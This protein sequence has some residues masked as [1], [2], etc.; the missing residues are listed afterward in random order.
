M[1]GFNAIVNEV[2]VMGLEQAEQQFAALAY[3]EVVSYYARGAILDHAGRVWFPAK[4]DYQDWVLKRIRIPLELATRFRRVYLGINRAG[5]TEGDFRGIPISSVLVMLPLLTSGKAEVKKRIPEVLEFARG[6]SVEAVRD[7][8]YQIR[9]VQRPGRIE[10]SKSI[11]A[12]VA[13]KDWGRVH[14]TLTEIGTAIG[15]AKAPFA[16]FFQDPETQ[17]VHTYSTRRGR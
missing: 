3:E 13:E 17:V 6:N 4:A 12:A 10:K 7:L 1:K 15:E 9:G 16:V 2:R 11:M 14:Q 5:L 8:T